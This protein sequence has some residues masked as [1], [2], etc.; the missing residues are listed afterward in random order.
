MG[1]G[2]ASG[3]KR[4]WPWIAATTIVAMIVVLNLAAERLEPHF[5]NVVSFDMQYGIPKISDYYRSPRAD[6]V[7]M[8]SSLALNGFDPVVAEREIEAA[9]GARVRALNLGIAGSAIDLNYLILKNV[10]RD[11]KKPAVIVY[12]MADFELNSKETL[13]QQPYT[14]ILLRWDDYPKYAGVSFGQRADFVLKRLLPLYRDR[15]LTKRALNA[16]FNPDDPLHKWYAPGPHQRTR[17]PNGFFTRPAGTQAAPADLAGMKV[18]N[19]KR[20]AHFDVA[21]IRIETFASFFDLAKQRGI[22]VVL[23]NM[24]V[25]PAERSCWSR[26]DDMERYLHAVGELASRGGI[27]L[28]DLYKSSG[29]YIPADG[30]LDLYHLNQTGATILTTLV[31][32]ERMSGYFPDQVRRPAL[33][34]AGDPSNENKKPA[35]AASNPGPES[36]AASRNEKTAM[37]DLRAP[38]QVRAK[39]ESAASVLIRNGRTGVLKCA[40]DK[41]VR[42]TYCWK[43]AG[44]QPAVQK[45]AAVL[46]PRDLA[47][48]ETV[49]LPFTFESPGAPGEYVFEVALVRGNGEV[50]RGG[51]RKLV[52]RK[53]INVGSGG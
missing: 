48:G 13:S 32:R 8:G 26:E 2:S 24:P 12:G 4:L 5:L 20:L 51:T 50:L 6:V 22:K 17:A 37:T 35:N 21:R 3:T 19:H 41:A 16:E 38:N 18:R 42:L 43:S 47:S 31:A 9:T 1:S 53:I 30:F 7:F 46:L 33:T 27:P 49:R 23:V 36:E 44:E 11:D 34:A 10:I 39:G 25:T 52:L 29:D 15:T 14:P 45:Q 40:G 28:V